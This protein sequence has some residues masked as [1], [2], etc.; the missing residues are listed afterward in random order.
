MQLSRPDKIR[1]RRTGGY[2]DVE[3]VYDG[4]TL[5]LSG[6][7]SQGLR[8]ARDVG[9]YRSA[10]HRPGSGR[11]SWAL[12]CRRMRCTDLLL[13]SSFDE[14][15]QGV[16]DGRHIGQGVI[17][18]VECEHL[19]FRNADTDWQIWVE[20]GARPIPGAQI[21]DY[22]QKRWP[23]PRSTLSGSRIGRPMLRQAPT[24]SPSSRLPTPR[25]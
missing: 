24:H 19:A 13:T 7:H 14:L 3:L 18:G 6:N 11:R 20:T 15:M 2:T 22:E 17:D 10:V 9:L 23:V 12:R 21:R 25:K 16:I 1:M 4:K 8:P 5:T